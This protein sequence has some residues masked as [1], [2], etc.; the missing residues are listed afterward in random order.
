MLVEFGPDKVEFGS[1]VVDS[2][3]LFWAIVGRIWARPPFGHRP[4]FSAVR[5]ST[6]VPIGL[7]VRAH[8]FDKIVRYLVEFEANSAVS[9]NRLLKCGQGRT[10]LGRNRTSLSRYRAQVNCCSI[11]GLFWSML[12]D[13]L[14]KFGRF[15]AKVDRT[16][17]QCGRVRANFGGLRANLDEVGPK[18]VDPGLKSPKLAEFG[19][20]SVV[21]G[22]NLGTP[23]LNSSG[24]GSISAKL[25]LDSAK[26]GQTSACIA[27]AVPPPALPKPCPARGRSAASPRRSR[28]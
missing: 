12:F 25:V 5:C 17:A 4:H 20:T 8:L 6:S 28:G 26:F 10:N 27:R 11:P 13:I 22:P 3:P 1:I 9:K 15:K 16:R 14:A 18:L 23:G 21:S 7:S 19:P 2:G 24:V